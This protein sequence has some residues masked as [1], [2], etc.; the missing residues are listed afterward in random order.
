VDFRAV[1]AKTKPL[2]CALPSFDKI[3][4]QVADEKPT[5]FSVL[6]LC[7]GYYGVELDEASCSAR[8]FLQRTGTSNLLA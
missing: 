8:H 1:N 4:H 3:L 5:I 7:A 2:Y 6:D